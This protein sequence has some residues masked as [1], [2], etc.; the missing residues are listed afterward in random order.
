MSYFLIVNNLHLGAELLGGIVFFLIAWLFFEAF[1]L[2]KDVF[3]FS[4]ALGFGLISLWQFLHALGE[5]GNDFLTAGALI[6]L[7]GLV[8]VLISYAGEK[9]AAK[10]SLAA[11]FLFLP[12]VIKISDNASRIAAAFLTLIAILLAKRYFKDIDRPI[13][14]LMVGFGI[15]SVAAV[16]AFSSYWIAEH[17]IKLAAFSALSIWIWKFLSLRIREEALI[18]F[19]A[20]SLFISL[21]V[22]TTFSVFFLRRIQN[23]TVNSLSANSQIF[24]F[25]IASLKNKALAASQ[26]IASNEDLADALKLKNAA[27]LQEI[28]LNLLKETNEEFLTIAGG[29]GEVFLKANFPIAKEENI[30]TEKIGADALE[31][32]LSVTV[33]QADIEGLSIRAAAPILDR[34]AVIGAAITGSL[35][36]KNFVQQFKNISNFETS[37]FKNNQI[38]ASSFL[39]AGQPAAPPAEKYIG[40]AEL[41]GQQFIGEFQPVKNAEGETVAI[42]SLT[43]TPGELL[44]NAQAANRLTM[45]IIFSITLGLMI[46]LYRFSVFLTNETL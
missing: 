8:L 26:I 12:F 2:K 24:N 42:F 11:G 25:Y 18:V 1:W 5:N 44:R 38:S 37:I 31:G 4:R 15:L 45:I 34:G 10:P 30:L 7:G 19:V 9:L 35:L 46:P 22:T 20:I 21:L 36:N 3:S 13:K 23:E 27:A 14:W 43:T 28:S 41:A 32:K 17:L 6:Y 39:S 16:T 33:S 29:K 40:P